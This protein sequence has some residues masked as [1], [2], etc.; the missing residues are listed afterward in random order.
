MPPFGAASSLA[1]CSTTRSS[2]S[3][4]RGPER[5][6]VRGKRGP[7]FSG[8]PNELGVFLA[9]SLAHELGTLG[10]EPHHFRIVNRRENADVLAVGRI[11]L[12]E[13]RVSVS[14]SLIDATSSERLASANADIP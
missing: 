12:S 2:S 4:P 8:R 14:S 6:E 9:A 3:K 7:D 1:S 11:D 13:H 5:N 10:P